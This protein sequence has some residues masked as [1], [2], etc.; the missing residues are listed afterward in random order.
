MFKGNN[1]TERSE[2]GIHLRRKSALTSLVFMLIVLA[3]GLI[4]S[5]VANT[6]ERKAQGKTPLTM[7][8]PASFDPYANLDTGLGEKL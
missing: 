8:T 2:K 4:F 6:Q 5:D 3:S 7:P 1:R